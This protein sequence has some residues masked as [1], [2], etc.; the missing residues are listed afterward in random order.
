M[1]NTEQLAIRLAVEGKDAGNGTKEL[2]HH[3]FLAD[4]SYI[5]RPPTEPY[6]TQELEWF[7]SQSRNIK[8]LGNYAGKVP[9]IWM[10]IAESMD[11]DRVGI[12]NSN[13]GWA[14]LSQENGSQ[15]VNAMNHLVLDKNSRHGLLVYN[16][17]SM[18]TDWAINRP[19]SEEGWFFVDVDHSFK[20]TLDTA[21]ESY[22]KI[23]GD[24]M[25]CQ[26]NHF[27]IRD[28][29]LIMMVQMRA[30]DALFGYNADY[31]WFN[32]L[33]DMSLL[34]LQKW[35]PELTRG[36]MVI[37]ADSV[38]V[39]DRN[40]HYLD[41][42]LDNMSTQYVEKLDNM[43]P[44]DA[45][46]IKRE[47]LN[48]IDFALSVQEVVTGILNPPTS[49][50]VKM[51][52]DAPNS[53]IPSDSDSDSSWCSTT[54][55]NKIETKVGEET[56]GIIEELI[57]VSKNEYFITDY[58]RYLIKTINSYSGLSERAKKLAVVDVFREE[59]VLNPFGVD[60][61]NSIYGHKVIFSDSEESDEKM[62]EEQ[63]QQYVN[64]EAS[65]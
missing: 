59:G 33:F 49:L 4:K 58:G 11:P 9:K 8:D 40:S 20:E 18:H 13:Y 47:M 61:V 21:R 57:G 32:Y 2:L 24:F 19:H 1:D 17:P 51:C 3:T 23:R 52:L 14:A 34:Y 16:R 43:V 54:P 7:K 50:S 62:A 22:S 25:C 46:E 35:Y 45:S 60:C 30:L 63:F 38:H 6:Q 65:R 48:N 12:I 64:T 39:Y 10:D 55:S 44:V 53:F 31:K 36:D 5:L 15:W 28:N 56:K 27:I 29:K 26:N 37:T 42:I 41:E